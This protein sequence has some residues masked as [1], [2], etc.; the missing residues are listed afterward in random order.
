MTAERHRLRA[1][2]PDLFLFYPTNV[3]WSTYF[4]IFEAFTYFYGCRRLLPPVSVPALR[5]NVLPAPCSPPHRW[6]R[7]AHF[8]IF[9][10]QLAV[11]AGLG[12]EQIL[13][14]LR[15][16]HLHFHV[17]RKLD[18][19]TTLLVGRFKE[20]WSMSYSVLLAYS[21]NLP[22]FQFCTGR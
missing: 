22:S 1:M 7:R 8:Q 15:L 10:H 20:E 13:D 19:V 5:R 4:L 16:L 11:R 12:R 21:C 6:S 17:L 3:S 14:I 18:S 9:L 2:P